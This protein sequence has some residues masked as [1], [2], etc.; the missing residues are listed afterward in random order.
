MSGIELRTATPADDAAIRQLL[1]SAGL[2]ADDVA[3]GPQQY[4][5]AHDGARLVG[6]VGVEVV[7]TDA[8]VRSLAV[9]PEWRGRGI[10]G[11]LHRRILEVARRRGVRALFLLT[12]TA[13]DYAAR[14]GFR[15]IDRSDVPPAIL[16]LPQF[17]RL[18][19]ASAACMRLTL[20]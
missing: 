14:R 11:A 16:A 20:A 7:G 13:E 1:Q 4:V 5:V 19:P 18:C 15:R 10:A 8:L 9:V 12:T 17:R 6:T 3:S 2:P